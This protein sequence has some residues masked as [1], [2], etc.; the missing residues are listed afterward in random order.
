MAF[1]LFQVHN[2][3]GLTDT[4]L[5]ILLCASHW[6]FIFHHPITSCKWSISQISI[7]LKTCHSSHK[8]FPNANSNSDELID[9]FIRA[10]ILKCR[11]RPKWERIEKKH[12]ILKFN[13]W[14]L[15]ILE[16]RLAF[17]LSYDLELGKYLKLKFKWWNV[18][19]SILLCLHINHNAFGVD[20]RKQS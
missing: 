4:C 16:L 11:F 9:L 14:K 15:R 1:I 17:C 19:F 20:F 7:H 10:I 8:G 5:Y 12:L 13:E 6:D 18:L 3:I 2:E